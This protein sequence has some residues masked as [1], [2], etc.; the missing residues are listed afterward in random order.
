MVPRCNLHADAKRIGIAHNEH[1]N[2][3]R[4]VNKLLCEGKDLH[5]MRLFVHLANSDKTPC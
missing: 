5:L 1:R 2:A 3:E 4:E